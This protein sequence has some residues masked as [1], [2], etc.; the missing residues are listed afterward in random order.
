MR[1]SDQAVKTVAFI[2][3]MEDG[4]F[5]AKATGFFV[6]SEVMQY[7]FASFVTAEHVV[8]G[9]LSKGL[10]LYIRVNLTNG[11][12]ATSPV[13]PEN[14]H[15]YPDDQHPSDVAI[16]SID[17]VAH[18][19]GGGAA[20]P[21]DVVVTALSGET[22]IPATAEVIAE[23]SIGVGEEVFIVGLFVSH[24]GVNR[25]LPII[26]VGNIAAMPQEPVR[27]QA[28][29][30]TDAYLIEAMSIGGLSGSPVYVHM[31]PVRSTAGVIKIERGNQHYLLGLVSGHFDV[32]NLKADAVDIEDAQGVLGSINTGIGVVI[33]VEKIIATVE[34]PSLQEQ[35]RAFVMALQKDGH[36]P[37]A[38]PSE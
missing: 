14:W 9:L 7:T 24:Y 31:A 21:F 13:A 27:T 8:S 23:R 20:V 1:V 28:A 34:Q 37:H 26:R 29:G 11:D 12:V 4:R 36:R 18:P 5:R 10:D 17:L 2:G 16:C 15:Y 6:T 3:T 33:P 19:V 38:E 35:R 30:Y 25:N 22:A 32:R